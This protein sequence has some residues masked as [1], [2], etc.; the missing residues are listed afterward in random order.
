M[1]HKAEALV[2]T[3]DL[4]VFS[5]PRADWLSKTDQY[6][7]DGADKPDDSPHVVG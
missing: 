4:D 2:D 5:P 7:R 6:L 1:P 3:D